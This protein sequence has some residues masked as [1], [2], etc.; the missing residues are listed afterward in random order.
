MIWIGLIEFGGPR[1]RT[2]HDLTC[3]EEVCK[4]ESEASIKRL[5]VYMFHMSLMFLSMWVAKL[6]Q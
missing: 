3:A 4:N 5:S 6:C 1:L 2:Q